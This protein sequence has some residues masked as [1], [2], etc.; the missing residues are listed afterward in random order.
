[1][2]YSTLVLALAASLPTSLAFSETFP[3]VAWS[4]HRSGALDHLRFISATPSSADVF[5]KLL[6]EH[7][8]CEYD[9]VIMVDQPGLHSSDLRALSPSS[10]IATRL[11]DSP[12]S[13]QLPY[14]RPAPATDSLKHLADKIAQLCGAQRLTFSVGAAAAAAA[15]TEKTLDSGSGSK[16]VLC[17]SM[18][19]VTGSASA[20]KRS[21]AEHEVRLASE[22][23]RIERAFPR[24]LVI[25]AGSRRQDDDSTPAPT[26]SAHAGGILAHYQLLT[27]ALITGLLLAFFVLIPIVLFGVS[28][29]ASIESPLRV[30]PPK[31]FNADEKKNQ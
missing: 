21:V 24:H 10:A 7:D 11:Q 19:A 22:L 15:A 28:A 5:S 9:A 14:V 3:V 12:S 31:G 17:L 2:R 27:P 29:L 8:V 16:H 25:F 26:P 1:M 23:E 4:S 13:V 6:F 30:Q 20:R 18:P